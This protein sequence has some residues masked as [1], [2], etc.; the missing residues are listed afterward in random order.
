M[1]VGVGYG[2]NMPMT[3]A[4]P[5]PS[6]VPAQYN[7]AY[8]F[9]SDEE[10]DVDSQEEV[11]DGDGPRMPKDFSQATKPGAF[12]YRLGRR[13]VVKMPW[14]ELREN[15]AHKNLPLWVLEDRRIFVETFAQNH[16][17]YDKV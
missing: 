15:G 6:G 3:G 8:G 4:M 9:P 17:D 5:P 13:Q 16:D 11:K 10:E 1:P 2:N 12:D 7:Y 14:R